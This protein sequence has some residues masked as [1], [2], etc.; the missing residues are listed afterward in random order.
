MS[1]SAAKT[2]IGDAL[3]RHD[4]LA[5]AVSGGV[6]SMLL[7][8]LAHQAGL[9]EVLAVHAV[10]PA[11]PEEATRRVQ[12]HARAHGWTLRLLDAG[13]LDDPNY[14]ANP[15][16]R[17][18]FCK[19]NLYSRIR[20]A[21]AL[22]IA[23]GTNA[24]DLGDYRPGLNAARD[25]G[26]VHPFVEADIDKA[27][28]YA[29]A[30]D[31]GLDDLEALPAQPCLASRIETGIA[32]DARTLRFI[33]RTEIALRDLLPGT[34]ALRCR[35]TAAGIVAEVS[36]MPDAGAVDEAKRFAESL[37]ADAGRV[38]A[39]LRPYRKGSAFLIEQ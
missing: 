6:D 2:R 7:T 25:H 11:V 1:L 39:G 30:A 10:S 17:C 8:H 9:G 27:A 33:E 19:T 5:I 20:A 29:L 36:P 13:E 23:S 38:F 35:V 16:D 3:S 34:S 21:T 14:V 18:F 37:C 12:R 22:P 32:V 24:D 4:A 26:V 28:I 15:V 31:L